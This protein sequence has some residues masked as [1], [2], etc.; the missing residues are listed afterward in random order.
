MIGG[1]SRD[2]QYLEHEAPADLLGNADSVAVPSSAVGAAD[3]ASASD[4]SGADSLAPLERMGFR[5]G[6]LSLVLPARSAREV[7]LAP[8]AR[9]V[10]NTAPWLLGL[11]NVRG[12]LVPVVD[13]ALAL[14]TPRSGGGPAYA[15]IFGQGD[16]A[17]ALLI[18]GLPSLLHIDAAERLIGNVS[19]PAMLEGCVIDAYEH[20]GRVWLDVNLERLLDSFSRTIAL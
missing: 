9:R 16:G 6:E 19:V 2:Q 5:V 17:I 3:D 14:G 18:D 12:G 11:A 15:L 13:T 7:A 1:L 8:D 4:A 10:P 20:G